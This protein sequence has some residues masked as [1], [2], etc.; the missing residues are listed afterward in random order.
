M[1]NLPC[2]CWGC[3]SCIFPYSHGTVG[4]KWS[5]AFSLGLARGTPM[6]AIAMSMANK[7]LEKRDRAHVC[8]FS[9]MLLP[10]VYPV[11]SL[12][13]W[14]LSALCNSLIYCFNFTFYLFQTILLTSFLFWILT[15]YFPSLAPLFGSHTI[16]LKCIIFAIIVVFKISVWTWTSFLWDSR[17]EIF[18]VS[19]TKCE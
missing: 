6:Q 12:C 3:S 17:W 19:T 11:L 14:F 10:G 2:H 1:L 18:P 13:V 5:P 9:A 4:V 16:I 8:P 15:V 7:H